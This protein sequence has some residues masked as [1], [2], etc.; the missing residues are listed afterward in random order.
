MT[1][2]GRRTTDDRCAVLYRRSALRLYDDPA[3]R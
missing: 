3:A 2:D 1:D